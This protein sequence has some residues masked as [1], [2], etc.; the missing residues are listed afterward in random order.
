MQPG[1][2]GTWALKF[3]SVRSMTTAYLIR[4][5]FQVSLQPVEPGRCSPGSGTVQLRSVLQGLPFAGGQPFPPPEEA[6]PRDRTQSDS[7]PRSA[8]S[9]SEA[10]PASTQ[11]STSSS[12]MAV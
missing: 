8:T 5:R 2:S 11:I 3:A 4:I 7:Q 1:R 12:Q 9:M 10:S 6:L